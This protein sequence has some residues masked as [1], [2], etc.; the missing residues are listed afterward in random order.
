MKSYIITAYIT[1]TTDSRS[2]PTLQ[3]SHNLIIFRND[4]HTISIPGKPISPILSNI[5][6]ITIITVSSNQP[7]LLIFLTQL[8][9]I[10]TINV[11]F[12]VVLVFVFVPG[13]VDGVVVLVVLLLDYLLCC[14]VFL[15]VYAEL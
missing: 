11:T 2:I 15:T 6:Q 12:A 1:H 5:P 9:L 14:P 3:Q 8:P 7:Q 13:T 10:L 4:L